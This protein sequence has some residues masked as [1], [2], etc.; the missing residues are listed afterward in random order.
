MNTMNGYAKNILSDS[1]VLTAAGGHLPLSTFFTER[2]NSEYT[3]NISDSD[4]WYYLGTFS[5]SQGYSSLHIYV[6]GIDAF[7]NNTCTVMMTNL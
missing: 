3:I 5:S 6:S 4:N 7:M 2:K 1:N